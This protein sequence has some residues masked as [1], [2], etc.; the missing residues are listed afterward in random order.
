M[1]IHQDSC[2]LKISIH[3][4]ERYNLLKITDFEHIKSVEQ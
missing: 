3:P 4:L 1:I 2:I